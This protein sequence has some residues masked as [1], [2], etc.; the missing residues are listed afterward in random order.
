[1][2][3][4]LDSSIGDVPLVG[5]AYTKKLKKLEIKTVNDLIYHVPSRYVDFGNRLKINELIVGE[6]A[7]IEGQI[8]SIKNIYT[9]ARKVFQAAVVSDGVDTISVT[10]FNQRYLI[11]SLPMGT[12]VSLSGK[13]GEWNNKISFVSPSYE[14]IFPNKD[15]VHTGRVIPV[16]PETAGVSSKWLRAKIAYVFPKIS[17]DIVDPIPTSIRTNNKLTTLKKALS[18]VHFPKKH[19]KAIEGKRRLAFDELLRFQ[20]ISEMR[21]KKWKRNEVI[22]K[23]KVNQPEINKFIKSL[24]F[25]LTKSQKRSIEE[26]TKDLKQNVPMNRLLEGDVGSGKTIVA[27]VAAFVSFLNGHQTI[28]MAPTQILANQHFN[29]LKT[30]FKAF[31]LRISLI[32]STKKKS[33]LGRND[34]FVGTHALI[35]QKVDIDRV[36]LVI[37]DEQHR[38]GVEQRTHLIRTTAGKSKS[39]HVLTMT[40]TPIPRTVTLTIYGDLD[41]STLDEM[42][43]GRKPITTWVVPSKKRSGSYDWMRKEIKKNKVQMFVVCPLIEESI[44]ETMKQVKAASTEFENFKN[45]FPKLSVGLLHGK[46]KPDEKE[47][48]LKN[49]KKGKLDILVSTPVVEVGIDIPNATIMVVET[50]ERFGLAQLHQLRGRVGRGEKNSYCLLF[51]DNRSPKVRARLNALK[52]NLSGFALAELDLKLRGPGEIFGVKQHGFPELKIASWQDTALIKKTRTLAKSIATNPN[53]HKKLLS[54]LLSPSN[55]A[56]N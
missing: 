27:A 35:H 40:A 22:Y 4:T 5:P 29:T 8:I 41:L 20:L 53:K 13:V 51:T 52:D 46:L 39:P 30:I 33:A 48:V 34:I 26:I 14:K 42:P 23:L 3:L 21:R 6:V 49:F 17:S 54:T 15:K 24:P 11:K 31:G 28:I 55:I 56:S 36:A 45:T 12:L 32:T 10:W 2:K 44:K 37:I 7:T 50:A 38:F 19:E 9:K 1:M 18:Q 25:T 47:K 16:Y 43:K